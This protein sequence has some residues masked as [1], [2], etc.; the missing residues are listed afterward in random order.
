MSPSEVKVKAKPKAKES[1]IKTKFAKPR[2]FGLR[3]KSQDS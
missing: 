1:T 2:V 3:K